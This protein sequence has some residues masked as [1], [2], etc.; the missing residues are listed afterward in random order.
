MSPIHH[1]AICLLA[2]ALGACSVFDS[3]FCSMEARPAIVVRVTDS[4]TGEAVTEYRAIAR[5]GAY[6]DTSSAQL[7]YM[8]DASLA[9]E[10]PGIY[11]VSVEHEAYEAWR[12]AGIHV[13]EDECHVHAREVHAVLVRLPH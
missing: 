5:D 13:I 4:A 7:P 10:R 8:H 12:T 11:E 1:L 6:A 2:V 9:H 3:R